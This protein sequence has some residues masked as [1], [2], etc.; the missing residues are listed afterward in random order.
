MSFAAAGLA[1]NANTVAEAAA[2]KLFLE[3]NPLMVITCPNKK[4]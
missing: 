4:L 2:I 1:A 3:I